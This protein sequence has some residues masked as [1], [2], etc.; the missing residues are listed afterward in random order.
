MSEESAIWI[1]A[2]ASS[3]GH[4][5]FSCRI[6]LAGGVALL[7]R[8]LHWHP[9]THCGL[10]RLSNE[11][12]RDGACRVAKQ[13]HAVVRNAEGRTSGEP[14]PPEPFCMVSLLARA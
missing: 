3:T 5:G 10:V 14:S 13:L 11:T 1:Y 8:L 2:R 9:R 7:P 6:L 12:E 4:K